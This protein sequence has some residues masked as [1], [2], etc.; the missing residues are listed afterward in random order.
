MFSLC[1]FVEADIIETADK[2]KQNK[3]TS[4]FDCLQVDRLIV[5]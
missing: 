5:F 4:F 2:N 1:E 3:Q